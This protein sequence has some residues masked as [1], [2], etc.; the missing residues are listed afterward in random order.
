MHLRDKISRLVSRSLLDLVVMSKQNN[1]HR[2]SKEEL[3]SSF[4]LPVIISVCIWLIGVVIYTLSPV[5]FNETVGGIL[6]LILVFFLLWWSRGQPWQMR[7]TAVLCAIPTFIGLITSITAGRLLYAGVGLGVTLGALV[8]LRFLQTPFSY[9]LAYRAYEQADYAQ[10]LRLINKSLE[11]RPNFW[12]SYELRARLRLM[13]FDFAQAE[14]DIQHA[15]ALKPN[16]HRLYNTLGQLYMV[17]TK[18]V[19]AQQ[20]YEQAIALEPTAIYFYY[21][22]WAS[23]EARRYETAVEHLM[24][25]TQATLPASQFDL[26]CHFYLGQSLTALNRPEQAQIAYDT[27]HNFADGLPQIQA[28][29]AQQ[30]DYPY[31]SQ[32]Q[33]ELQQLETLLDVAE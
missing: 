26:W 18:F 13:R 5:A 4:V 23:Y 20:A 3:R 28:T 21:A 6:T 17:Q 2:M 9:R 32:L 11:A 8:L 15:L 22:G 10:S 33:T 25:A 19:Q 24:Q 27:M 29:L 30:P 16:S 31:L 12:E 1:S 7:V 14:Q